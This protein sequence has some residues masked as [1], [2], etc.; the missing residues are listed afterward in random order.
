MLANQNSD[1]PV[2]GIASFG[3]ITRALVVAPHPDDES[4]GCGGLIA[5]L[6][7]KGCQISVIFVTD[8]SGSHPASRLWPRRRLSRL[9]RREAVA[10][11]RQLGLHAAS[12]L[13][14]DLQDAHMPARG[15]LLW[16]RAKARIERTLDQLRPDLL[17]L[18]WRR[19]PHCDHRNSWRLI[20]DALEA[21]PQPRYILEYAIWL[22]ELGDAGDRPL[23]DEMQPI[24]VDVTPTLRRKQKAIAAHLSQTT[25]LI[26]DDPNGFRLTTA[27]ISR[28]TTHFERY[29]R[30]L[31][32]SD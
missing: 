9:R 27:T 20:R 24:N 17:L 8:G 10:A 23:P 22:D 25:P 6:A 30:P 4:L 15:S 29:W 14:L 5:A 1:V 2:T 28:L 19:D 13:F 21:V 18:P 16:N 31:H 11:L 12:R 32:E 3:S 7:E 26:A